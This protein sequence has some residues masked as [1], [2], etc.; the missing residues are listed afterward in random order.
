VAEH[1]GD[2]VERDS[3]SQ[4]QGACGVTQIAEA[5]IYR[6]ADLLVESGA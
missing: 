6:E 3:L 2:R 5:D 1:P 4:G